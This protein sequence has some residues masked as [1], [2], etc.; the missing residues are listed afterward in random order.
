M[1]EQVWFV[2]KDGA[3]LEGTFV[4]ERV[5][6]MVRGQKG[7]SFMV[8]KDG[9]AAW[10]DPQAVAELAPLL[11]PPPPAAPARQEV[12]PPAP[13]T[14]GRPSAQALMKRAGFIRSLFDLSF[15][16]F[17]TPRMITVLY[18]LGMVVVGLVLLAMIVSGFG[19][20][21]MGIRIHA[22]G[23]SLKGLL[24][25]V[26]SPVIAVIYLALIRMW[27][28]LVVVLFKIKESL[29][30]MAQGGSRAPAGD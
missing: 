15:D 20:I 9:M 8:W 3:Q 5:A 21:F 25:L 29:E 10:S 6:E 2:V 13:T 23:L 27:L 18:V 24:L 7:S 1:S 14:G 12:A 19:T 30:T 26:L 11:A 17:V 22:W 28:E 4:A 16:S